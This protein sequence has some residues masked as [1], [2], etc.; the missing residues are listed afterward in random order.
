[1]EARDRAADSVKG[2]LYVAI[3]HGLGRREWLFARDDV[4]FTTGYDSWPVEVP[5]DELLGMLES[6]TALGQ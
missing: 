2:R 1:M 5:R 6:T 3:A 4:Q